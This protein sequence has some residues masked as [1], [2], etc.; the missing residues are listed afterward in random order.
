MKFDEGKPLTILTGENGQGK[1]NILESVF[2]LATGK[3]FREADQNDL[4]KWGQDFFIIK[5]EIYN[6]KEKDNMTLEVAYSSYP[7][8]QKNFKINDVDKKHS[9]YIGALIAVIFNPKDINLL[10]MEPQNRRK[11][12]NLILSQ[13]DKYYLEALGEYTKILKQR[14]ALLKEISEKNAR[15]NELDIWDEKLSMSGGYLTLERANFTNYLQKNLQK[16]YREISNGKEEIS[17]KYNSQI[18]ASEDEH[19]P[20]QDDL[21]KTFRRKLLIKRDKDILFTTTSVGPHRDDIKFFINGHEFESS[22]SRG[23]SRTLLIALKLSE[24]SYIKNHKKALPLLLLD[25]VFSELDEHRQQNLFK[26]IQDCQ[27]I[28][29]SAEIGPITSSIKNEKNLCKIVKI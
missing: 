24:I 12:I 25:D 17:L 11:Y 1:T 7:R 20:S 26:A 13:T 27:S 8:K 16:H 6:E 18:S 9:E 2:M 5:G 28:I 15:I 4:I 10:Y 19:E 3:T 23:E 29:T 21:A 22:A 14:N